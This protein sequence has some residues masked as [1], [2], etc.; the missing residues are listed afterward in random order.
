MFNWIEPPLALEKHISGFSAECWCCVHLCSGS[1][2]AWKGS[3]GGHTAHL[4]RG[5]QSRLPQPWRG[6]S[7]PEL[8]HVAY[9]FS[10]GKEKADSEQHLFTFF[11][12]LVKSN[13]VTVSQFCEQWRMQVPFGSTVTYFL[14]ASFYKTIEFDSLSNILTFL[15]CFSK[16]LRAPLWSL[17]TRAPGLPYIEVLVCWSRAKHE[18]SQIYL[19]SVTVTF[20]FWASTGDLLCKQLPV[21]L[22]SQS[23]AVGDINSPLSLGWTQRVTYLTHLPLSLKTVLKIVSTWWKMCKNSWNKFCFYSF[24]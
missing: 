10:Q 2:A 22:K 11:P 15:D 13:S 7:T 18:S 20:A 3:M 19:F 24:C 9:R 12:L 8:P 1:I 23:S 17:C 14:L 5:Q 21:E 16:S 4:S 6:L